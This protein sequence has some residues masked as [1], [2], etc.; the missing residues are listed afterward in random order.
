M[1]RRHS[2]GWIGAAVVTVVALGL[3]PPAA[4]QSSAPVAEHK[5]ILMLFDEERTLPG[6][7]LLDQS[8]APPSPPACRT[9]SSSSTSR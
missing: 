4:A 7:S 9:G 1:C 8:P 5:Q 3:A 6:L 2:R